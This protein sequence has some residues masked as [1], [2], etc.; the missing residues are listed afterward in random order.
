MG[1]TLSSIVRRGARTA[2]WQLWRTAE[3]SDCWK[4]DAIYF[5]LASLSNGIRAITMAS[6]LLQDSEL[7]GSGFFPVNAKPSPGSRTAIGG[8]P[9]LFFGL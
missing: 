2:G 7:T 1:R 4:L 5:G 6:C 3:R 8:I 9:R